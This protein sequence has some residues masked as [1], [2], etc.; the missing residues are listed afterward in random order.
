MPLCTVGVFYCRECVNILNHTKKYWHD[1]H[2]VIILIE[3]SLAF[4]DP[5]MRRS[6]LLLS[7]V[8]TL[9]QWTKLSRAW[10]GSF[11]QSSSETKTFGLAIERT[12]PL[13]ED[14]IA[15]PFVCRYRT[16]IIAPLSTKQIHQLSDMIQKH[17]SLDSLR[18]RILDQLPSAA[19]DLRFRVETSISKS[20]LEDIYAPFKPASKGS[21]EERIKKDHP[22]LVADVDT[23]WSTGGDAT[24]LRLVPR[25][26]AITLLANRIASHLPM[27][28]AA[29]EHTSSFCR[30]KS[31]RA[32]SAKLNDANVDKYKVYSDFQ[33]SFSYLKVHQ[34]LAIRRGVDQKA[35]KLSYEMDGARAESMI[36]RS[37]MESRVLGKDRFHPLW[38]DAIHDAWSRL[39][40]KRCT[41]RLWKMQCTLAEERS[42][43]VFCD[44]LRKALLSPPTSETNPILALDP[45][46]QAGIKCALLD[47]SGEL[48]KDK[49]ALST[50]IFLK[51]REKGKEQ[52]I[53]LL[54]SC[55]S[56]SEGQI[57]V[58]LGNGHGTQEARKL[59]TE[60][61]S[62]SGVPIKIQLVSEAGASVWSVTDAAT[63]EFPN[64]KPAA[65][66]AVSI[67]RRYLNPLAELVKIPPKSL[68]LGMYQHDLSE[69][70]LD[71]KL[72]MTSVDAVAEVG[73]DANTCSLEILQKV[74]GMTKLL[75]EKIIKARPLRQRN[76]LLKISGLGP[77][78]FENCAAFIRFDGN[79]DLDA[80][81]VHP[82]SY[83]LAR[84]LLAE[85][86]WNLK[87]PASVGAL[88]S[89]EDRKQRWRDVVDKASKRSG[90]SGERVVAVID[91]LVYSITSPD[92][93]LRDA[94]NEESVNGSVNGCTTL[95]AHLASQDALRKACPVRGIVATVRNVVDFG[96]FVDFGGENDGLLHR[97]KLGLVSLE[98]LSVGQEVGV[99]ILGVS[100]SKKVSVS[101]AGL[102]LPA[103]D[104]DELKRESTTKENGSAKRQR[105]R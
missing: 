7:M 18:K 73:V 20:E 70:E 75:C 80:T 13:L 5:H 8:K 48:F 28:D 22:A 64:E 95:P 69:K 17:R 44:N 3:L 97:S 96:A 26:A 91:H 52:M 34:V 31:S 71:E 19:S 47:S 101:L 56:L 25:D 60:A 74:P 23:F 9:G 99:D 93:R 86:R 46:F 50:V 79:E 35:L 40:R 2:T 58:A 11:V 87:D 42:I 94:G 62:S 68:G 77:K 30:V 67:G 39:V 32:S 102:G 15:V 38:K 90:V 59:V 82:E 55:Q 105:R 66:A 89:Q 84:W 37:L 98:S 100:R 54:E 24:N 41:S 83:D 14:P 65:I 16:D 51:N 92:P 103:E 27:M 12:L 4:E 49:K 72:H 45:G 33:S 63:R 53:D 81:L 78:T 88:P 61:A 6:A 21:L 1:T 57:V 36:R 85:L 104:S 76:D 29:L 43:A 10:T